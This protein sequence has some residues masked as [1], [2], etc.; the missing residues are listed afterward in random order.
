MTTFTPHIQPS[1]K[2]TAEETLGRIG[3][4]GALLIDVRDEGQFA[5]KIRRGVRGGH[6]PGAVHLPREAFF[7]GHGQF[8]ETTELAEMVHS[9]N[10]PF[11]KQV[12]AY[13]NGGVAATSVLFTLSMLGFEKLSN[14][15]GS[16]NEWNQRLDLP[17]EMS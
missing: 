10:I 9:A 11:E 6:I 8:R 13:C 14:Y 4:P 7:T 17:V 3:D 16:W 15:D 5:G 2:S 12:I 1:W